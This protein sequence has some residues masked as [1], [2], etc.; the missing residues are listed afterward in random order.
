MINFCK[1]HVTLNEVALYKTVCS[2]S[3]LLLHNALGGVLWSGNR[4]C[5]GLCVMVCFISHTH[6]HTHK[7]RARC[8]V[9]IYIYFVL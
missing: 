2:R 9:Y 8:L 4:L 3:L 5:L 1:C 7:T 6:T